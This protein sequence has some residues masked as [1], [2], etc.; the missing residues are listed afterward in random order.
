MRIF[1]RAV[2]ARSDGGRTAFVQAG[3]AATFHPSAEGVT[4]QLRAARLSGFLLRAR[5]RCGS[6]RRPRGANR[7]MR[8]RTSTPSR[9]SNCVGARSSRTRERAGRRSRFRRSRQRGRRGRRRRS[10]GRGHRDAASRGGQVLRLRRGAL[11]W[12]PLMAE[13]GTRPAAL[14]AGEGQ[15]RQVTPTEGAEQQG[16]EPSC[17]RSSGENAH[18][19]NQSIATPVVCD[20]HGALR[21]PGQQVGRPNRSR[22]CAVGLQRSRSFPEGQR[23]LACFNAIAPPQSG[24]TGPSQARKGRPPRPNASRLDND[25]RSPLARRTQRAPRLELGMP[26]SR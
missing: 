4:R 16:D 23:S 2:A 3:A 12:R 26:E 21:T 25:T 22:S 20:E 24:Q 1:D 17:D 13:G 8:F 15:T 19:S 5:P 7:R 6:G 14:Q 10:A 11:G 9:I 18:R